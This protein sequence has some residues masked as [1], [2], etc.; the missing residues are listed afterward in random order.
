MLSYTQYRLAYRVVDRSAL[1]DSDTVA[2]DWRSARRVKY[3]DSGPHDATPAARVAQTGADAATAEG[4]AMGC[5]TPETIWLARWV[6]AG[7]A[8]VH[9]R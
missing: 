6:R 4:E 9:P 2:P 5:E 8:V 3:R 7:C 1:T